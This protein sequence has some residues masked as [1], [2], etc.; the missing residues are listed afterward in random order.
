MIAGAGSLGLWTLNIAR[1]LLVKEPHETKIVIADSDVSRILNI[2]TTRNVL[3][4]LI[5]RD[6]FDQ[7]LLYKKSCY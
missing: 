5:N 6:L 3:S 2:D 4:F 7:K 1:M